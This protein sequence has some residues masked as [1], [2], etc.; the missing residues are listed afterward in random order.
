MKDFKIL[1]TGMLLVFLAG[2]LGSCKKWLDV[3]PSSQIKEAEL[4]ENELGFK[5]ALLGVYSKMSARELYSDNLTMGFL[6]V[7]AQRYAVNNTGHRLYYAQRY[8]YLNIKIRPR[9]DA[10]WN[11]M[12]NTIANV[13]NIL[14]HIEEKKG[15]FTGS[16]FNLIK[17]ESLALRAFMHFDLLRLFAP[18]YSKGGN[19]AG[20]PYVNR[21]STSAAAL[22]TIDETL[23]YILADLKEAESL[24]EKTDPVNGAP[25]S[26]DDLSKFRT[27]RM[28]YFAVKAILARVYLYKGD[29]IN[30]ALC[31]RQVVDA[32]KHPFIKSASLTGIRKD[33]T[34]ST[35]HIFSLYIS[36]LNEPVS[37]YFKFHLAGID[38]TELNH[39]ESN[40]KTVFEI[41][42][43]GSTDFRYIYLWEIDQSVKYHSKFW[44]EYS[45]ATVDGGMY[46]KLMPLIRISEMFY[47]L[48]ECE[49]NPVTAIGYLNEIRLHRGVSALATTLS[50]DGV[51]EEILKEYKKEFF[52]EGQ[53]FYYYKRFSY[54][55]VPGS[56][57][58]ANDKV[59][60]LPVPDN[61]YEFRN[62]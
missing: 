22:S 37:E 43:G 44:Q 10:I 30:A 15:V 56:T 14:G 42:A 2:S 57:V 16:N 54:P 62:K 29:K 6:D 52:S 48:A 58:V 60:V 13:N 47:I 32:K 19:L 1:I 50:L 3:R 61:E 17:G 25:V 53:L 4:F 46:T 26:G 55:K 36:K 59:Y 35:E 7:L 49:A 33:R 39:S 21:L 24:L 31:A 38:A 51:K 12:Y 41:S 45:E 8:D 9:I 23:G 40:I 20:I 27:N 11:E 28:N 5:D 34:F 18:A